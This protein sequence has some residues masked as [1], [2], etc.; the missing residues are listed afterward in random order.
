MLLWKTSSATFPCCEKSFNPCSL[1][2]CSERSPQELAA[3]GI[4][5]F[6]SLF[7]WMLLWKHWPEIDL[8]CSHC[9]FNPCSLG[10]CSERS[11]PWSI[12]SGASRPF[13]SLFSWMLLW[14][15]ATGKA[16]HAC[17]WVSILVL[18]DV[19]LKGPTGRSARMPSWSFNP[20]SLGCCSER[21]C[22]HYILLLSLRGFNPCSLGCC[23]ER[24]LFIS[25]VQSIS[26]FNPCSLGCCSESLWSSH[27]QR[28]TLPV[29]ILVL[30]DVALKGNQVSTCYI[31]IYSVSI[32]VLLDVAL[33]VWIWSNVRL[34]KRVFQ[35]LFSWM[36]LWKC[37]ICGWWVW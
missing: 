27:Y 10:C 34:R 18:L 19:A 29:S 14:K 4:G 31:E 5:K 20:C 36:L 11:P 21:V 2:C 16:L 9:G 3:F 8:G 24:C 37:I 28:Y 23:S 22:A 1:G 35:S 12:F 6:Q 7:S 15:G 30:L 13:Q 32:L 33:K 25:T 26:S 17:W